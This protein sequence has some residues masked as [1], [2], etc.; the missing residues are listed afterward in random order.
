[1]YIVN[2]RNIFLDIINELL[3]SKLQLQK[4]ILVNKCELIAHGGAIGNNVI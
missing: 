4:V 2:I 1:M 3:A